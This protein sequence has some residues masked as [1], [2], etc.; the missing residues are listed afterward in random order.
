MNGLVDIDDDE[1]LIPERIREFVLVKQREDHG[2]REKIN[3]GEEVL[4]LYGSYDSRN[5]INGNSKMMST[6]DRYEHEVN[7]KHGIWTDLKDY[8]AA[9]AQQTQ[10][11][12]VSNVSK[13]KRRN[14]IVQD[15][16]PRVA[17][18]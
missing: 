6:I 15:Y 2:Y 8:A 17:A 16:E 1:I 4:N 5:K 14:K 13:S 10:R 3:D 7:E 18:D 12:Q 9:T 11:S